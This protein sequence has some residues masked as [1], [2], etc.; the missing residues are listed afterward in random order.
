MISRILAVIGVGFVLIGSALEGKAQTP[1]S[2]PEPGTFTLSGESLRGLEVRSVNTD[3][4]R[5]NA[6]TSLP[7]QA[8]VATQENGEK[9]SGLPGLLDGRVEVIMQ[10]GSPSSSDNFT[11]FEADGDRDRRV[12]VQYRLTE[13]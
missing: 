7:G 6:G 4:S 10:S 9:N 8:S 12:K 13:E 3:F 2:Q 5:L 11:L 1:P